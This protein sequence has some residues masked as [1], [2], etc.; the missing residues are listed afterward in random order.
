[1]IKFSIPYNSDLA[2]TKEIIKRYGPRIDE[3][4]FAIDSKIAQCSKD[5]CGCCDIAEA[6]RLKKL[7]MNNGIKC[8]MLINGAYQGNRDPERMKDFISAIGGVD[9]ITVADLYLLEVFKGLGLR[10]H[11]SRLAQLNTLEKVRRILARYPNLTINLDNDLNR[12]L[13][14]LKKI[15]LLRKY[16]PDFKIKLM[17]NE[18]CLFH[19]TGRTRHGWLLCLNKLEKKYCGGGFGCLSHVSLGEVDKELIKSPFIRPEDLSFYEKNKVVDIFKIA[20]RQAPGKALITIVEAYMQRSYGGAL[21]DLMG[22]GVMRSFF[23]IYT[24]YDAIDNSKFPKDFV[25]NVATCDKFC[26][27]CGYCAN[28]A[29]QVMTIPQELKKSLKLSKPC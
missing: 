28:I 22:T 29:K 15:S 6:R 18:G 9:G 19:C 23:P 8:N 10:L 21:V 2:V 5:D 13:M 1:M 14:S 26:A 3:I 24:L 12:D 4:Y 16:Y 20:G 7:L 27:G 11:I 17:V 25:E